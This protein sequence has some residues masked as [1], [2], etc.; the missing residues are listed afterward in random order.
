MCNGD[1]PLQHDPNICREG[2]SPLY[3][4]SHHGYTEI[5]KLLLNNNA[6]PNICRGGRSPLYI[7]SQGSTLLFNNSSTISV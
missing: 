5:V 1:I 2:R 7:A 6:D 4:A 3:I